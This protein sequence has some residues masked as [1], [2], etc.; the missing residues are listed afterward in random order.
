M[1]YH[2]KRHHALSREKVVLGSKPKSTDEEEGPLPEGEMKCDQ[3]N[4][5]NKNRV[6]MQAHKLKR[7]KEDN[8]LKCRMCAVIYQTKDTF[9][10]T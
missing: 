4:Y 8:A 5:E 10:N 7:H 6:L 2:K 1:Q 9:E 3:S